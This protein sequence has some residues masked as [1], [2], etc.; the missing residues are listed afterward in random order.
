MYGWFTLTAQQKL[1]DYCKATICQ[2][3][4]IKKQEGNDKYLHFCLIKKPNVGI[5]NKLI[6]TLQT[7]NAQNGPQHL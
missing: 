6:S 3:K 2:Q 4:R 1:T 5:K 7:Q